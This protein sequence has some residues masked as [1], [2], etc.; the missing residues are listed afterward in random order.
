MLEKAWYN[1]RSS[2]TGGGTSR[3]EAEPL[4]QSSANINNPN[5]KRIANDV[6]F[7]ADPNTGVPIYDSYPSGTANSQPGWMQIGGTSL[8]APVWAAITSLANQIRTINRKKALSTNLVQN[9]IYNLYKNGLIPTNGF[10]YRQC[11]YDVITTGSPTYEPTSA[12]Y[13]FPTGIG[14]PIVNILIQYLATL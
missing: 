10:T 4:Y 1:S 9:G 2:S 12:G 11:F 7:L 3:Y 8:S 14:A 13:D 5:K 6:S